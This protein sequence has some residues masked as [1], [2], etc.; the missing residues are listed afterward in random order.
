MEEE[1][2]ELNK[3]SQKINKEVK[4]K[5]EPIIWEFTML[6]SFP[7]VACEEKRAEF[8][9]KVRHKSVDV[10]LNLCPDCI[11][12]SEEVLIKKVFECSVPL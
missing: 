7:C 6:G 1:L 9:A 12:L 4:M 8:K 5:T 11:K 3:K 2:E 10:N